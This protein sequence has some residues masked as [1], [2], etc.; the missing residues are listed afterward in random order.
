MRAHQGAELLGIE[1]H[2][3]VE[4][5]EDITLFDLTERRAGRIDEADLHA[6]AVGETGDG[7]RSAATDIQTRVGDG[8]RGGRDAR[9]GSGLRLRGERSDQ[10]GEQE[11]VEGNL[12]ERIHKFILE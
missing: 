12:A 2:L 4:P 11:H 3:V 6:H 10:A 5:R 7:L 9:T 8:F 1:E